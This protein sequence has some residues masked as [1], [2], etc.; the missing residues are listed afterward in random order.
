VIAQDPGAGE[1]VNEGS[2]VTLTVS[3]GPGTVSVPPVEGLGERRARA[4]IADAGLV[5]DR[6]EQRADEEVREG[7]VVATSPPAGMI[8]Q[9]GSEVTL[10]VSSGP[11]Q[12]EVPDV[13]GLSQADAQQALADAG[14]ESETAERESNEADP[15]TVLEQSPAAHELADP[16][17]TV[18]LTLATE[19]TQVAVPDVRGQAVD[20]AVTALRGAGFEPRTT[21]RIVGDPS[22]DGRVIGQRPAGGSL[23]DEGGPVRLFVGRY[24]DPAPPGDGSGEGG[25]G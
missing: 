15:G 17:A 6:V 4:R 9:R 19:P 3:G 22:Q 12:V 16:G 24:V 23:A 11:A 20:D 21:D 18:T 5:V 25:P 14:F 1:R 8:V 10:F 7:R 2:T 13:V